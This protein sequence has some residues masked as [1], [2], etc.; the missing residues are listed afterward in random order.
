MLIAPIGEESIIFPQ[1]SSR[2]PCNCPQP[3]AQGA[4]PSSGVLMGPGWVPLGNKAASHFLLDLLSP[5]R[6]HCQQVSDAPHL[7]PPTF[8]EGRLDVCIVEREA[9]SEGGP[10]SPACPRGRALLLVCCRDPEQVGLPVGTAAC[11]QPGYRKGS[12]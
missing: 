11:V 5:P 10:V 6:L 9:A 3:V 2:W 4:A 1:S 7:S 12:G 8:P